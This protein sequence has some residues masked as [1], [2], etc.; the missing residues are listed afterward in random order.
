M[1]DGT[2]DTLTRQELVDLVRFLSELGKVGPYAVGQRQLARR[3]EAL[4][5]TPEALHQIRRTSF[6]TAASDHP[7][8]QWEPAYSTVAGQ[9]PLDDL[10]FLENPTY[11]TRQQDNRT[12]FLRCRLDVSS[13][14]TVRLRIASPRHLRLWI[15]GKPRPL[16][17]EMEL[18]L[19]KG[20]H[21]LTWSVDRLE[22]NEPLS[23][24]LLAGETS[25]AW[26][27]GK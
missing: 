17:P 8:L 3:W 11:V 9:L 1:P 5:P 13:A 26:S 12:T 23:V 25:A 24:E 22:R 27:L 6:D 14:G 2:V 7:A 4:L 21:L 10:P 16:Q 18:E 20:T 15:N 19:E